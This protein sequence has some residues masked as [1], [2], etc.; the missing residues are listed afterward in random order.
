MEITKSPLSTDRVYY[1]SNLECCK[2]SNLKSPGRWGIQSAFGGS[3]R[4]FLDSGGSGSRFGWFWARFRQNRRWVCRTD[5]GGIPSVFGGLEGFSWIPT[6]PADGR[7][8]CF[9]I[10]FRQFSV[11]LRGFS[12]IP[13]KPPVGLRNR[14]WW[15]SVDFRWFGGGFPGF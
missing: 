8:E 4:L 14:L 5:F 10:R 6:D 15:D 7:L 1:K 9:L 13:S 3:E 11:V 2:V 12:W